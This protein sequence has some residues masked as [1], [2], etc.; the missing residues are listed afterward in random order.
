MSRQQNRRDFLKTT[1]VA[2]A[3]FW[4]AGSTRADDKS[5]T[6]LEQ[7]N[8]ACIG[9]GGN[10]CNGR[11]RPRHR[12]PGRKTLV[13]SAID[14]V[15]LIR[16]NDIGFCQLDSRRLVRGARLQDIAGPG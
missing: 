15:E 16:R 4:I 1:T 12:R 13:Q 5:K 14:V 6:A 3:G 9:V 11:G 10:R 2:G 8:F 7:I